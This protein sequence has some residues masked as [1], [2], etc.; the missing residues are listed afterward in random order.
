VF[1]LSLSF[2]THWRPS[3]ASLCA[4]M[5]VVQSSTLGD[6]V[7]HGRRS[8]EDGGTSPPPPK[9]KIGVGDANANCPPQILSYRYKKER[10]V[11]FK[12]YQNPF[13]A[14]NSAPDPAGGA[15][16]AP[17]PPSRPGRGYVSPY[18]PYLAPTHLR[19]LSPQNSSQ[20]YTYVVSSPLPTF[21]L[22]L[23][24]HSTMPYKTALK[25]RLLGMIFVSYYF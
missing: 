24:L 7:N 9:K 2:F 5:H 8:R 19:R 17:R 23:P 1:S 16:D 15:Q 11:A 21:F 12:I 3:F 18:P 22:C 6:V 13:S 4:C 10:F 14:R 20:I 25:S